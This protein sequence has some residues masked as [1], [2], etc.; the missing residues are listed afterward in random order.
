MIRDEAKQINYLEL[1]CDEAKQIKIPRI[2][3]WRGQTIFFHLKLFCD[4]AKQI[5]IPRIDLWRGQTIFFSPRI[6]LWWGQTNKLPRIDLW[7][8]QAIFFYLELICGEAKQK[9]TCVCTNPINLNCLCIPL[10]LYL[11][12]WTSMTCDMSVVFSWYCSFLYQ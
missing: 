11:H 4:E 1:I 5:K 6:V 3:L 10:S 8:G 12:F 7:R 2:D 9:L